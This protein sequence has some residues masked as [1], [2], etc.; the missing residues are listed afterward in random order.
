MITGIKVKEYIICSK[1]Y[2]N[3]QKQIFCFKNVSNLFALKIKK[4]N[5]YPFHFLYDNER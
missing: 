2:V 4:K 3:T 1:G 5:V